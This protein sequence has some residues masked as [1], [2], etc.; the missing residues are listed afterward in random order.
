V[1][2]CGE[3]AERVVR[4]TV[5]GLAR[6]QRL[7]ETERRRQLRE[8]ERAAAKQGRDEALALRQALQSAKGAV[9]EA[10]L[11]YLAEREADAEEA[12]ETERLWIEALAN[13]L[14]ATLTVDDAINFAHLRFNDEPP[15]FVH[16]RI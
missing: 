15:C 3:A 1:E 8:I 14:P 10:K 4:A 13:S 9:R 16:H 7:A 12:N 6:Q 5:R 2:P 11:S